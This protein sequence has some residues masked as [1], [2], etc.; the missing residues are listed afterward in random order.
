M[1]SLKYIL[2]PLTSQSAA[3]DEWIRT[4]VYTVDNNYVI[5]EAMVNNPKY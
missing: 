5:G 2:R 3:M 1:Q 4:T